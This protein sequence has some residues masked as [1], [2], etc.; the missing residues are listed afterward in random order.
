MVTGQIP[1]P[2]AQIPGKSQ[3]VLYF[4]TDVPED[5]IAVPD[6]SGMTLVSANQKAI[7][8]GLYMLVTG[9]N[10]DEWNTQATYQDI[11]AGTLVDRGTTVTVEFTDITA[12][13]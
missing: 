9:V 7:N 1:A 4:G 11:P 8:N 10:R 2:G 6:F 5:Q 12:E 13:D 3:V